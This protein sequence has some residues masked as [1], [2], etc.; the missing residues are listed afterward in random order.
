M[1]QRGRKRAAKE[2]RV[3]T[4]GDYVPVATIAAELGLQ[5]EDLM[6]NWAA[7]TDAPPLLRLSRKRALVSRQ[8]VVTWEQKKRGGGV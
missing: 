6:R 1:A 2:A 8:D 3:L 7:D 5:T 4:R